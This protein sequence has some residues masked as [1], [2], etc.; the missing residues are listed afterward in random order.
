MNKPQKVVK[1]P[2]NLDVS[3]Q[4]SYDYENTPLATLLK[5]PM[6]VKDSCRRLSRRIA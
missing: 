1:S 4:T 5:L 6:L 2:R 3:Q